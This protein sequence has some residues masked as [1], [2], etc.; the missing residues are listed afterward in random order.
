MLNLP[1]KIILC[2]GL[3]VI[4]WW[5][6][7]N[8]Y[9]NN[10]L[11]VFIR[12]TQ[13]HLMFDPLKKIEKSGFKEWRVCQTNFDCTSAIT[14]CYHWQPI[15]KNHLNDLNKFNSHFICSASEP[16]GEQPKVACINQ[17][18]DAVK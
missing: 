5:A 1:S 3:V 9:P 16:P 17:E 4:F 13:Y 11:A 8:D 6:Y 18:C 10:H 12:Q 14:G 15:N 7:M 2:I